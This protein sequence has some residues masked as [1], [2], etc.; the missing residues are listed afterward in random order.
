MFRLQ[1]C[2]KPVNNKVLT[3]NFVAG[4]LKMSV[5]LLDVWQCVGLFLL[6]LFIDPGSTLGM[7]N[8]FIRNDQLSSNCSMNNNEATNA[9]LNGSAFW[10]FSSDNICYMTVK[11][12]SVRRITHISIQGGS[13]AKYVKAFSVRF[14]KVD[15]TVVVYEENGKKRVS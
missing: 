8:L 7:Q 9:R 13:N 15:G 12:I 2:Y 5:D 10:E 3:I 14:K 4:V 1:T 6:K 11:L